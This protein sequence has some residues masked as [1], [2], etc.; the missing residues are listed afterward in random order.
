MQRAL[1]LFNQALQCLQ[2]GR[3]REAEEICR[4][5]VAAVPGF[6]AAWHLLGVIALQTGNHQAASDCL[7]RA[8]ALNPADAEALN[9]LGIALK[10]RGLWEEALARFE[11]AV[12][13]RPNFAEAYF[14]A[15]H[16]L[17][18][19][20]RMAEA[21][22][23]FQQGLAHR[24]DAAEI[25]LTLGNAFQTVGQ[26]GDAIGCY[27][28]AVA[29]LPAS[30]EALNYLG[31]ACKDQG[32]LDEALAVY[33]RAIEIDPSHVAAHHNLGVVLKEIGHLEEAIGAFRQA[34]AI[35][36]A[37]A[38]VH[39][40]LL[41][42]LIY[43]RGISAGALSE[44]HQRWDDQ[45]AKPARQAQRPHTNDPNPNR[46]LRVGYVG[47]EGHPFYMVPL[48]SAHNHQDFEWFCYVNSDSQTDH[49]VRLRE[50]SNGWRIIGGLSDTQLAEIIREDRI[51]ILVDLLMHTAGSRLLMF[52]RQ[53]AP[54]QV[55]WLAY[56]G[57]TGLSAID[58]R[59]TDPY[60]D[61]PGVNDQFYAEKSIRLPDTFWCYDPLVTEQPVKDCPAAKN[62]FTT[63]GSLNNLC[64][65]DWETI[66][67]WA[68]ILMSVKHSRLLFRSPLGSHRQQT[69]HLF[70]QAGVAPAR[71][72]LVEPCPRAEYMELY[73]RIDI[74]LDTL[75]YNG[76]T[77]S[78]DALW[79]GVPIVTQV[80]E[81]VVGRAGLSLLTNLGLPEL[82][83]HTTEDYVRAAQEL[84]S[85]LSRLRH[86]HRTLRERMR[87]SPLM[88][89]PG[90]TRNI[91]SAYRQM[92]REWCV[93]KQ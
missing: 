91:E 36:P 76:H 44:E 48:L 47:P 79:M 23:C 14:N 30:A 21:I 57:T 45:H 34:L 3:A 27:R 74:V 77:T 88:D 38:R 75:P 28:E 73:D 6:A 62:G 70:E 26:L 71:I 25:Y 67:H 32:L 51:D 33:R 13:A 58:Y 40:S 53:P 66:K 22:A 20:A 59:L 68:Q 37:N 19:Q 24:P 86:L 72:D 31:A 4:Q 16:L 7:Q 46:R 1:D 64:K 56:P 54:V 15:G 60:L 43:Q 55:C 82:I 42:S 9:N 10:Y 52:A 63:F 41:F 69:L 2:S 5:L 39:S 83:T 49:S 81:T 93:K 87:A 50:N 89:A 61:P 92:W 90:F 80:G 29:R 17:Q 8:V 85:N 12:N 65:V 78:L 35:D 84:A 18:E 11:Q